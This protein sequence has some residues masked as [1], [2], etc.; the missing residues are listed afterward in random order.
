MKAPE[1]SG[2]AVSPTPSHVVAVPQAFAYAARSPTGCPVS[3]V[4]SDDVTSQLN[5]WFSTVPD[6]A[7]VEFT[8][9]ACYR[10]DQTLVI[11]GHHN[12][13]LEGNGATFKRVAPTPDALLYPKINAH[14]HLQDDSGLSLQ[15]FRIEGLN[16]VN[17]PDPW[18][19]QPEGFGSNYGNKA[20][21]S[22]VEI[23]GGSGI[24]IT[25]A[26]IDATFG[27]GITVG[28]ER[29]ETC[30]SDVR[31]SSISIDRNGRQ[32]IGVVCANHVL[33]D[34]VKILHSHGA[35]I[36]LE[37]LGA[38]AHVENV[39]ILR[40][41]LNAR[42]VAISSAGL[43]DISNVSVHGNTIAGWDPS[44]PWLCLCGPST[45][46]RHDWS[47][48]DNV[49]MRGTFNGTTVRFLN[50]R[51]VTFTKNT[52]RSLGTKPHASI[53]LS[54]VTGT[55]QITNNN[56]AGA[57]ATYSADAQTGPVLACDNQ[58]DGRQGASPC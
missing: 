54:N 17:S 5:S 7:T 27:D 23:S 45:S 3:G 20:F 14:F 51:N 36:D 53:E 49:T 9:S 50:V 21:E 55:I 39:E 2:I 8:P 33:I 24:T 13:T 31:L 42:T 4:A 11:R 37:P 56:L 48:R 12:I 28:S 30:T 26:S 32:G 1:P 44:Y 19:F 41:Y 18:E 22:G 52:S 6:G 58:L 15:N 10:L 46:H 29:A 57:T 35:G 47:V 43:R 38:A 34:Q 16:T 25:N 40:S